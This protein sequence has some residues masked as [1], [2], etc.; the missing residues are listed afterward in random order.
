MNDHETLFRT[1]PNGVTLVGQTNSGLRSVAV[2]AAVKVGSRHERAG[3]HGAAHFIE[4]MLFKG[5][6]RRPTSRDIATPS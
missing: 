3:E 2:L 5:T 4:H 1:L 6:R